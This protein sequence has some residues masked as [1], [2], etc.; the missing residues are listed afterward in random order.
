MYLS[1][2]IFLQLLTSAPLVFAASPQTQARWSLH[3]MWVLQPAC[4]CMWASSKR[5]QVWSKWTF[6]HLCRRWTSAPTT[7]M[8]SITG[9]SIGRPMEQI[10]NGRLPTHS[11]HRSLWTTQE[12]THHLRS[13]SRLS[14]KSELDLNQMSQLDT[15]E[16]TVRLLCCVVILF[17]AESRL[18]R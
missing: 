10:Y 1:H 5:A 3:G 16:K 12:R 18:V 7:A 4:M 14:I 9:C 11:L 6:C 13:E 8:A 15:P 17:V 2:F